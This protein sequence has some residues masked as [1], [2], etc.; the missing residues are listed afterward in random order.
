MRRLDH[1]VVDQ[2]VARPFLVLL[3]ARVQVAG[4]PVANQASRLD[5][6]VQQADHAV[7]L[8]L[9]TWDPA[10]ADQG[11]FTQRREFPGID[12]AGEQFSLQR[13][14]ARIGRRKRRMQQRQVLEPAPNAKVPRVI[15]AGFVPQDA[16]ALLV[17]A[18]VLLGEGGLVVPAQDRVTG[19]ALIQDGLEFAP[20]V[21][22]DMPTEQVGRP[23][24]AADQ[25]AQ[26]TGASKPD[27]QRRRALS[28]PM[29]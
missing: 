27:L 18:G 26:L 24:G 3:P 20:I 13:Q 23:L 7:I 14:A 12:H 29:G 10:V 11:R 1:Q 6:G 19:L 9:Q 16:V 17:A 8:E 22:G 2:P 25:D 21:T 5:Q 4:G 15:R 28:A